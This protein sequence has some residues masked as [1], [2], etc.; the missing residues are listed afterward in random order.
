M[1]RNYKSEPSPASI[2]KSGLQRLQQSKG[3]WKDIASRTSASLSPSGPGVC[4]HNSLERCANCV[5]SL[6]YFACGLHT[7]RQGRIHLL[8]VWCDAQ[9][10]HVGSRLQESENGCRAALGRWPPRSGLCIVRLPCIEWQCAPGRPASKSAGNWSNFRNLF[11]LLIS[12]PFPLCFPLAPTRAQ[13]P[14]SFPWKLAG[15]W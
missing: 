11:Y 7:M 10:A 4:D 9:R 15:G 1:G 6:P 2:L 13:N 5:T 14:S 12:G 3:F 8:G